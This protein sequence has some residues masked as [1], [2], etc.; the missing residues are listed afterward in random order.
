M[1]HFYCLGL[2]MLFCLRLMAQDTTS[3]KI[4]DKF[5][6]KVHRKTGCLESKADK[7]LEKSLDLYLK[8]ERLMKAKLAL[9]DPGKAVGV[10]DGGISKLEQYKAG[11]KSKAT[12]VI[13]LSN[14]IGNNY[15][16]SLAG[17]LAFIK[18]SKGVI[19]ANGAKLSTALAD[20]QGLK[21]KLQQSAEIEQF[22]SEH[23]EQ[24]KTQLAQYSNMLP[25]LKVIN[26]EYYYYH[27]Q[28]QE[29]MTVFRDPKKAEQKA[30]ALLQKLPA[31]TS[32][33]KKNSI[34][35]G[36]FNLGSDYDPA[37]LM[38]GQQ[39]RAMVDP[40]MQ[41][42]MGSSPS[43]SQAISARIQEGAARIDELKKKLPIGGSGSAADMPD[44][45]P[46]PLKTKTFFQRLEPGGNVQFQKSNL[47]YPSTA[48]MA[49]QLAYKMNPKSNVG[50]GASYTA[51][52][53]SGWDH[54]AF[55][56]KAFGL[57]SFMSYKVKGNYYANG[58]FEMNKII[59]HSVLTDYT[60]VW[61]GWQGSALLGLSKQ[62]RINAKL[63]GNVMLLYDFWPYQN[64][65]QSRFKFR[66]GYTR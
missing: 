4:P 60:K 63:K 46:K 1:K 33:I 8:Q 5:F 24:L 56:H 29:Y 32:F 50:L 53:G 2:A 14:A 47:L 15:V 9:I 7:R 19:G 25:N 20:V 27:A 23:K 13:P 26:Q 62:Y 18:D 39:T 10:F 40:I 52:L 42:A 28:V 64:I 38:E 31:Y 12:A 48:E 61:N 45:Q 22:I 49:G 43:A 65:P 55:S 58:G 41:R 17:S 37:R 16:D 36:L 57:R 35:A 34:I 11:L 59:A 66:I 54:I 51:G 21:G 44:F 30:I 6:D 3:L